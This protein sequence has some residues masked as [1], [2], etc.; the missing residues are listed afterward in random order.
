MSERIEQNEH[1]DPTVES[2]G[3]LTRR[4]L[5]RL[6]AGAA[7]LGA[8]AA[9][10][11]CESTASTR[12]SRVGQPLPEDPIYRPLPRHAEIRPALPTT[13]SVALP[14]G[15]IPRT[16]W[17]RWGP[18]ESLADPMT[19][20]SRITIHHDGMT[21]FTSVSKVDAAR[22]LENIRAAHRGRRWADIGYHYAID[23]AGRV[24]EARPRHLQGAH[25]KDQ[26]PGNIGVLV[27]GNF[28]RQRP[29]PEAL[30]AVDRF[31]ADEMRRSQVHVASVY[32]H[33]ELARTACPGRNLQTYMNY[34]RHGQGALAS[35]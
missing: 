7:A 13:P 29:T 33:Q 6:A 8:F 5:L 18:D 4:G 9:M 16:E 27:M 26:N 23:P 28:E 35:L 20:I 32:T 34:T 24:W 2:D 22:R 3:P 11:G 21:P 30:A 14:S 17:A 25:V 12:R 10:T 19:R 31:I 15:V 1:R